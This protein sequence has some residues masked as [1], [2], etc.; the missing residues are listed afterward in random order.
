VAGAAVTF[1]AEALDAA[2]RHGLA[3]RVLRAAAEV[4]RRFGGRPP[5]VALPGRRGG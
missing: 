2:A 4:T 5:R 1:P 3:L